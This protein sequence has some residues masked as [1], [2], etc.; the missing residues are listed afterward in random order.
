MKKADALDFLRDRLSNY[1]ER[2]E[3]LLSNP[4][5]D[6][7]RFHHELNVVITELTDIIE[8]MTKK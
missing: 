4:H 2:R 7:A 3:A 5:I 8:V 6:D 1:I